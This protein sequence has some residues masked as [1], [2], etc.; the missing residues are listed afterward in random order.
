VI[1]N[2]MREHRLVRG[3][4]FP[5]RVG[6][7]QGMY[8]SKEH[9]RSDVTPGNGVFWSIFVLIKFFVWMFFHVDPLST[10]VERGSTPSPLE[11]PLGHMTCTS[12][13]HVHDV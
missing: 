10:L 5:S 2:Q 12:Q 6:H 8:P 7:G 9:F 4:P 11:Q 3:V 13:Q 1:G